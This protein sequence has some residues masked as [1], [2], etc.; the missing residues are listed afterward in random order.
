MKIFKKLALICGLSMSLIACNKDDI[1]LTDADIIRGLGGDTWAQTNIDKWLY[2]SLVKPYNIGV[3]Y[4]WDQFEFDISRTLIPPSEDKVIPVWSV[5][6]DVWIKPY[7]AE[8][9]K[10]FFNKY[11][12]KSFI[13]AGS[14]SYND[15]GSII[16]GTAE[17]GRKIV[18]YGVNKFKVKGMTGYTPA[19]DS[20]FVKTYFIQTMHH[21]FAH[22]LHQNVLYPQDFKRINPILFQGQN[23]INM[24]TNQSR[25]DGFI[26]PYASSGFDDDFA[27]MV[28]IMLIEGKV[29]FDNI[30]NG[31]TGTSANGT[32]AA[33]AKSYLR[34][35]ESIIVNYYKQVWDIDFYSLQNRCRT[36]LNQYL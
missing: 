12:P 1:D 15:D 6:K 28:A 7:I 30:V 17:G 31:L 21:E 25:L 10:V 8:A 16:L 9:G 18:F 36:A 4:K 5:L 26:T 11:S 20:N 27:E 35:K 22:I 19:T 34:Q 13:L 3:K 29:G 33:N 32:T 14:N 23:W 24:A 2:D